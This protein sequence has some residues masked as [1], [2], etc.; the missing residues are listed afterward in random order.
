M[1]R[2][3]FVTRV[4][5]LALLLSAVPGSAH[6]QVFI[7]SHPQPQFSIGPLFVSASVGQQ[8][9]EN[10]PRSSS[11]LTVTVSWSLTLPPNRRAAD[12]AQDLYLLWPGEVVGTP[13]TARADPALVRQVEALGFK[14][15]QHGALRL[16]ARARTEMGTGAEPRTVG[17]AP[18]VAFARDDGPAAGAR[19]AT[20]VR[21]PWVPELAWTGSSGSNCH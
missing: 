7:A 9:V 19:G 16:S 17:E 4:S 2:R 15:K 21:I 18:F 6:A 12:I 8:N 5:L 3:A 10:L 13:G 11:S 14:L 20:Y 1:N